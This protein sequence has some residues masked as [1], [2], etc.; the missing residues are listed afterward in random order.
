VLHLSIPRRRRAHQAAP[1][2]IFAARH[3]A[4]A[5]AVDEGLAYSTIS[6]GM[7]LARKYLTGRGVD[8]AFADRY[9][10]AYGRTAAKLYRAEHGTEPR[11]AW[12]NVNGTWRR[13]NGFLPAET[14]V[15]DKAFTTYKRT[16]EY[17][18]AETETT[19]DEPTVEAH[20]IP[21]CD[22][23]WHHEGLCEIALD[24]LPL[25]DGDLNVTVNA[26]DGKP[27]ELAVWQDFAG[28]LLRTYGRGEAL[29]FADRIR[30]LADSI[31]Q[32]AQLLAPAV[33]DVAVAA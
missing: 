32:G 20:R 2:R 22:G 30:R 4:A 33:A 12:S 7:L 29:A 24:R 31:E 19:A 14:A 5:A 15:L 27:V 6:A 25:S 17:V 26:H 21:G 8:Q 9:G 11:K 28:D 23:V 10:S 16:A 1:R 3:L 13:V 18:M